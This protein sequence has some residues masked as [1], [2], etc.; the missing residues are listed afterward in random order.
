MRRTRSE[1][2][3]RLLVPAALFCAVSAVLSADERREAAILELKGEIQGAADL[4]HRWISG[5]PGHPDAPDVAVHAAS[6]NEDAL[7]A[8]ASLERSARIITHPGRARVYE[9]TAALQSALG[10]PAE[11][12]RNYTL[13]AETGTENTD[14]R[15]LNALILRFAVGDDVRSEAAA[16]KASR[17]PLIAAD[18]AVLAALMLARTGK[19]SEAADELEAFH[20]R[21][22]AYWLILSRLAARGGSPE[23][24]LRA[25]DQLAHHYPGS[26]NLYLAEARILEWVSPSSLIHPLSRNTRRGVQAGAFSGRGRAASLRTR[27]EKDGFTAW[28]EQEGSLW[29][30]LVHDPDGE[31][32]GRLVSRGYEVSAGR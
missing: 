14:R 7:E 15:R 24:R 13:A 10:L 20:A 12:A 26:A 31:V 32:S 5:N 18:A 28:I 19:I 6:L 1:G 2:A 25:V 3:G 8:L 29:K 4:Y 27:L 21:S 11:A 22:P 30:V 17:N 16:L 23:A 9:R